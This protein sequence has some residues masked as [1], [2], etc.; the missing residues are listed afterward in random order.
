M[1]ARAPDAFWY[2]S[3]PHGSHSLE[4]SVRAKVPGRHGRH[5][6]ASE[7]PGTGLAV[8]TGHGMHVVLLLAPVAFEQ[9]SLISLASVVFESQNHIK[10][11]CRS[12]TSDVILLAPV[13]FERL[14]FDFYE[15]FVLLSHIGC[16]VFGI[17][18]NFNVAT[19]C[20]T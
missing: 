9:L 7:L 3:A 18:T 1:H 6:L 13:A 12:Q 20:H 4:P 16:Y 8:P 17:S 19:Q 14:S 5:R 15:R 10:K 11:E 2:A